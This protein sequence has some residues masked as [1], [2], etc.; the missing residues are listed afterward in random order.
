M[1]SFEER[2][3]EWRRRLDD[4]RSSGLSVV[5]W[6]REHGIEKNTFYGWRKR[7]WESPA[8]SAPQFIAVAIDRLV[9]APAPAPSSLTLHI[10][11][12]AVEVA[13]GFDPALLSDVLSILESR[14]C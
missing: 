14:A 13:S 10:G 6:C 9:E 5:A 2:A 3:A 4:Q 1:L 11:R 12:V 8:A 7:L